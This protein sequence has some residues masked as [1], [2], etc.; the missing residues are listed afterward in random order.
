MTASAARLIHAGE[1][2]V[3]RA[4]SHTAKA[5]ADIEQQRDHRHRAPGGA[6]HIRGADIAAALD[7]HIFAGLQPHQQ[8]SERDAANQVCDHHRD[9][10]GHWF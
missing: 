6:Q 5:L 10:A 1:S 9:E 8:I 7:A 2:L 3:S 4:A